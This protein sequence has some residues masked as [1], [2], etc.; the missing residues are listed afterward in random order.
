MKQCMTCYMSIKN[1][2]YFLFS[3]LNQL[4]KRKELEQRYFALI[5]LTTDSS[6]S[7]TLKDVYNMSYILNLVFF[8]KM[9]S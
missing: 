7:L 9:S 8:G 4:N 2:S 5:S 1:V 6:F 3:H